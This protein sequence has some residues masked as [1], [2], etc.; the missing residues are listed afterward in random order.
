MSLNAWAHSNRAS[1]GRERPA[2]T[3]GAA[4]NASRPLAGETRYRVRVDRMAWTGHPPPKP[5]RFG[6]SPEPVAELV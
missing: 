5:G 1:R 2:A 6:K 4:P 3:G